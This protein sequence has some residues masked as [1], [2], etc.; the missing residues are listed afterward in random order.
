[1]KR[2][3]I[4]LAALNFVSIFFI[5]QII[6]NWFPTFSCNYPADKIEQINSLVIDL[7]IGVITSTLFYILLVY[8]PDKKKSRTARAVNS[9]N[10]CYLAENMQFIIIHL[11]KS[12][13]IKVEQ[14]DYNYSKIDFEEFSKIKSN[15]F[16][17]DYISGIYEMF[18]RDINNTKSMGTDEVNLS[19]KTMTV[20]KLI[21][22]T[23][24]M[25]SII[26]EDGSLIKLLNMIHDCRFFKLIILN[27]LD[28]PFKIGAPYHPTFE[29]QEFYLLYT[30]LLKY[31]SPHN[32][33][34]ERRKKV[35]QKTDIQSNLTGKINSIYNP[36]KVEKNSKGKR[37]NRR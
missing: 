5:L 37:K 26:F 1:M 33:Y 31:T 30:L 25:P 23:L 36:S 7:S 12:Y 14:S 22:K 4:L 32:F 24:S 29:I 18:V 15:I 35:S 28:S 6:F 17:K 11:V 8:L 19:K 27:T 2:L 10:L 21:E 3:H 20:M 16:S 34:F 9:T 13:G